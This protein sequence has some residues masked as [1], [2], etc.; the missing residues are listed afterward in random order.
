MDEYCT[1][2]LCLHEEQK[3]LSKEQ[4]VL[5][6]TVAFLQLLVE[7]DGEIQPR[8]FHKMFLLLSEVWLKRSRQVSS[9]D[10]AFRCF[11]VGVKRESFETTSGL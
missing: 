11:C 7:D 1:F 4:S 2:S 9:G 5:K 8:E 10:M 3:I 6:V